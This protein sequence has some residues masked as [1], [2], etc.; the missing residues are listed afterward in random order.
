MTAIRTLVGLG[1]LAVI[2]VFGLATATTAQPSAT[3]SAKAPDAAMITATAEQRGFAR[4]IVEF[5]AP[6]PPNEMRPDPAFLASVKA[7]I[8]ASQD[9]IIAA[10]FGSASNPSDGKGFARG[11][12][13]FDITPGF[14]VNVDKAELESLAADPR[15]LRIH[16][17][18]PLSP[19]LVQSVPLI[20][21]TGATGAYALGATGTGQ[22]IAIVDTGVQSNHEFLDGNLPGS[23]VVLEACFSNDGNTGVS[24]CP[25]GANSQL[26]PGAAD[27]TTTACINGTNNLCAHG[28]HVA[29]IAAGN[30]KSLSPG[31]PANGVAKDAKIVAVQVFTRFNSTADCGGNTPPCLGALPSDVILALGWV[32]QN[33]T[34]QPGVALAAVNMSLGGALSPTTCDSDPL[35][36]PIDILKN[37]GVATV[38]ASGNDGSLSS[39]SNPS[40]ISI[41]VAVGSSDK[42][43]AI[44]SFSNMAPMVAL[45]APGSGIISSIPTIPLTNSI[46]AFHDG[47]S[48]AAPHV[49]GCFAAIRSKINFPMTAPGVDHI[50]NLLKNSGIPIT[51]NRSGTPPIKIIKP[52]IS[53]DSAIN[54]ITHPTPPPPPPHQFRYQYVA[55]FVCGLNPPKFLPIRPS[56]L[57]GPADYKTA[58]NV[59]NPN[60]AAIPFRYKV[61]FAQLY[62][63]G[64]ISGFR[65]T[66]IG[67]D[68]AQAFDCDLFPTLFNPVLFG[69]VFDGFFV[70]ESDLPLDVIGYYT[71]NKN[72]IAIHVEKFP[73]RDMSRN[74]LCQRNVQADL[75]VAGNWLRSDGNPAVSVPPLLMTPPS[76]GWDYNR[77]WMSYG[78]LY[79]NDGPPATTYSYELKFCSCS[80]SS[81]TINGT[82]KADDM[83]TASLNSLPVGTATGFAPAT[84]A[85]PMTGTISFAGQGSLVVVVTNNTGPTGLSVTGTLN[86]ADGYVGACRN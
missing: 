69:A 2:F 8:A 40:C 38:I 84:P 60:N 58:I 21:M 52:R 80:Q 61:A 55:K 68:A 77:L 1:M 73:G 50:E 57:V 54:L 63:D 17:D 43:D 11:L 64:S 29:G 33:L 75:S 16:Y 30:N 49:A 27:A 35:F 62:K 65:N 12:R 37:V 25:N 46:Y 51:D 66:N 67:S 83:A 34:P 39:V 71:A 4:I 5:A 82:F 79:A 6:V 14:A 15:V 78:P 45:M 72:D 47:T 85:G 76:I 18:R 48:M 70:I 86:L 36:T 56:T 7:R 24:L 9:A 13:R 3:L 42:Q 44:S 28:T 53:C 22:A 26:G 10:H 74:P 31:E 41:A 81:V 32:Y 20:G 59:H 19:T 23:K